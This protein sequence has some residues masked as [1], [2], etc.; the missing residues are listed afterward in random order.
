M[1][2]SDPA[3]KVI[4]NEKCTGC[5]SCY[6]ACPFNAIEM[7]ESP[8]GFY[9]PK[10]NEKK[11]TKCG[12]CQK[13]CPVIN[14]IKLEGTYN[15]PKFYAG[16]SRDE[17]IRM[18][19]SSGGIF[20]EIA[21][22]ILKKEGVVYGVALKN[23]EARHIKVEK[24]EELEPLRGSKYLQSNVGIAYKDVI[25]EAKNR[26]VLFSG[27]PCQVAVLNAFLRKSR[28]KDAVITVGVVCYGVPSHA[29]F[30]KYIEW[31]ERRY[32]KKVVDIKFRDKRRGWE[33]PSITIKFED[34]SEIS[35]PHSYDSFSREYPFLLRS[36][37]YNCSFASIPRLEDITLGDFWGAP[38][39]LKDQR[40]VSVILA[41]TKIGE[42]ILEVLKET[43]KVELIEVDY[44]TATRHNPRVA[45]GKR[46]I[47]KERDR[48]LADIQSLSFKDFRQ[49]YLKTSNIVILKLYYII[50]KILKRIP[51]LREFLKKLLKS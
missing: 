21:R 1:R 40:G 32:N 48:V 27:T 14:P 34:G 28:Y 10:I 33:D 50:L 20:T 17:N 37:C 25:A 29:F 19:S 41:N 46:R 5:F 2:T 4:G 49:K 44:E 42:D 13:F 24:E 31:M 23:L 16:W 9:Y 45:T 22:Y 11:C 12:V 30:K 51:W 26:P 15:M 39:S 35:K 6:N 18:Q 47:P 36:S 7:K 8:E 3:I 43:K 38:E